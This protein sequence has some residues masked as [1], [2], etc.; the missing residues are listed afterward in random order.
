MAAPVPTYTVAR[1]LGPVEAMVRRVYRHLGEVRHC[2]EVVEYR[3]AQQLE[4]AGER[5]KRPG[6][7]TG[8]VTAESRQPPERN[9]PAITQVTTGRRLRI[10]G[11][12]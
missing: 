11:P 3:V 8:N 4:Q 9:R 7:V 2:S 5:L 12:G 6:I 10:H 1:E